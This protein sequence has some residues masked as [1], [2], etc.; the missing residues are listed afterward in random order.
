MIDL[1]QLR[2]LSVIL[3]LLVFLYT[4]HLVRTNKLGAHLAIS[5]IVT[6]VAFLT[7]CLSD[8]LLSFI[9]SALGEQNALLAP[10]LF[11]LAWLA[12]L[13]LDS[14][15]RISSLTVK[16]KEV[17]QE[18]ALLRERLDRGEAENRENT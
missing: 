14:L 11:G 13:T 12:F 6:E 15:T 17:N 4:V 16:L 9:Q 8:W 2:T 5:W 10:S 1:L 18:L 7:L 3:V